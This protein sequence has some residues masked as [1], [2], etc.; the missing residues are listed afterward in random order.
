MERIAPDVSGLAEEGAPSDLPNAVAIV[1]E[2]AALAADVTGPVVAVE[3]PAPLPEPLE[4]IPGEDWTVDEFASQIEL[5]DGLE[6]RMEGLEGE[7]KWQ[8]EMQLEQLNQDIASQQM[9]ALANVG[10]V[11]DQ[12]DITLEALQMEAALENRFNRGEGTF[13]SDDPDNPQRQAYDQ[14]A[15]GNK[16]LLADDLDESAANLFEV[17]LDPRTQSAVTEESNMLSGDKATRVTEFVDNVLELGTNTPSGLAFVGE[18]LV[19]D[20]A[21]LGAGGEPDHLFAQGVLDTSAELTGQAKVDF[22][23]KIAVLV[24]LDLA[25]RPEE[26]EERLEAVAEALNLSP[27]GVAKIREVMKGGTITADPNDPVS[28]KIAE[29]FSFYDLLGDV[30]TASGV[31]NPAKVIAGDLGKAK[32]LT[33]GAQ[34]VLPSVQG[35]GLDAAAMTSRLDLVGNTLAR[36]SGGFALGGAAIDLAQGDMVGAT[37]N[38]LG[39]AGAF[40]WAGGQ[41]VVGGWLGAASTAIGLGQGVYEATIDDMRWEAYKDEAIRA[42]VGDPA[43]DPF[44]Q[45]LS[46]LE[47]ATWLEQTHL[48]DALAP[49]GN[50]R[51]DQLQLWADS[52]IGEGGLDGNLFWALVSGEGW[53]GRMPER[54]AREP[55]DSNT[56]DPARF[57]LAKEAA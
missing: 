24:G 45:A 49:P 46:G 48:A 43:T 40:L 52:F 20:L 8:A 16:N 55:V 31:D 17:Y 38:V 44:A 1:D 47:N 10:P 53:E 19:D 37:G 56:L 15:Q 39:A 50:E 2:Q 13:L 57:F 26:A 9:L 7:E 21:T 42:S 29:S 14:W 3:E 36:W 34:M 25:V 18:G 5:R 35:L 33:Q 23:N 41:R 4:T 28:S 11:R 6:A 27:E 32:L 22:D 12:A 54:I 30:M 51:H